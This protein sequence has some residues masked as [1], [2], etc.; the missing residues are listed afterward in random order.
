MGHGEGFRVG[1]SHPGLLVWLYTHLGL[2]GREHTFRVV[3]A[4]HG[5]WA[6][7]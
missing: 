1:T 5:T 6:G 3:G 4:G 2:L 7:V